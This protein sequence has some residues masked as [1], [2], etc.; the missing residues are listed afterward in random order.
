VRSAS[1][2]AVEETEQGGDAAAGRCEGWPLMLVITS[3]NHYPGGQGHGAQV[4]FTGN[5]K[6]P[7]V[8]EK[9]VYPI[10]RKI[11]GFVVFLSEKIW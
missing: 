8:D 3:S 11:F 9:R 4:Y 6:K 5:R 1:A 2:F 7:D 10:Y